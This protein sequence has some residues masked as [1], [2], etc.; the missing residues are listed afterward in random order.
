MK[1]SEF[2]LIPIFVAIM[3]EKNLSKAA[4]KLKISQPAVSQGLVRLRELYKDELFIRDGRGVLP[5][6]YAS[7]IY[8]SLLESMN[9]ILGTVPEQ[10]KFNPKTCNR[11]FTISAL[12]VFNHTF[13]S[14]MC[15][16]IKEKAP[17]CTVNVL[18]IV[19]DGIESLMRFE[20]IDLLIEA[21][22]DDDR[23]RTLR[24]KVI[25]SESLSIIYS[26]NHA[27]LGDSI[28]EKEFLKEKHVVHTQHGATLGYLT[29]NPRLKTL[30]GRDVSW[31]VSN[32]VDMFPLLSTSD[33]VGIVPNAI[34]AK[35][36]EFFNLHNV[37]NS[38][39]HQEL[40]I[41][42]FW[43]PRRH[44]DPAHMWLRNICKEAAALD[45]LPIN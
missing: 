22:A 2:S 14:S 44:Q 41:A 11:T 34:A 20:K 17:L 36:C 21:E 6:A 19:N 24:S 25:A 40:N 15:H 3:D 38:F 37:K 43:H 7:T 23:Y 12:S 4:K 39:L 45:T 29:N 13:F 28:T 30:A 26:K 31:S 35:Y 32:I 18:P 8:P 10:F 27:R 1:H 5:T 16:L 33:M 9:V 42:M